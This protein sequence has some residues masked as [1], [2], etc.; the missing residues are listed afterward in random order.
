MSNA[1]IFSISL[2]FALV[3]I[4]IVFYDKFYTGNFKK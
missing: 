1:N 4:S 2:R 3:L